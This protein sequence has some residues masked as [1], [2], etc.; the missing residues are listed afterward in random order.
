MKPEPDRSIFLIIAAGV[1]AI[2]LSAGYTTYAL[3]SHSH[4]ACTQLHILATAKG[5]VT[6]YD[7]QIK[8]EYLALYELRCT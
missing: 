5:A 4:Q 1:L 7:R 8:R 6:P 2:L 3:E